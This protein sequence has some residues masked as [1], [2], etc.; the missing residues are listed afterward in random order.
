MAAQHL[1]ALG[2]RHIAHISGPLRLRVARERIAGFEEALADHGLNPTARE[3]GNWTCDS[4]YGAMKHILNQPAA[5]NRPVC[6]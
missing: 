6:S 1:I 3:E 5:S 4:G 2:H